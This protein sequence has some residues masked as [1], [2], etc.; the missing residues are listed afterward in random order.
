M[1]LFYCCCC[2][3]IFFLLS[4][5]V[6]LSM[7]SWFRLFVTWFCEK[8]CKTSIYQIEGK[9]RVGSFVTLF[10]FFCW[11]RLL[12]ITVIVSYQ[13][14][15]KLPWKINDQNVMLNVQYIK[16]VLLELQIAIHQLLI[17]VL[18]LNLIFFLSFFWLRRLLF[19]RYFL[20]LK[21]I[22]NF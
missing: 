19:F 8:S 1:I 15:I 10:F 9:M 11:R 14:R 22:F 6:R 20:C 5:I 2:M 13:F 12:E 7:L 17:L 4:F 21:N 16:I 3:F 18:I